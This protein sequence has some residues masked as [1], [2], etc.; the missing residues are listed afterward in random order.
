MIK[1]DPVY[2]YIHN[3]LKFS[4]INLDSYHIGKDI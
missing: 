4:A 2:L 1:V 3:S